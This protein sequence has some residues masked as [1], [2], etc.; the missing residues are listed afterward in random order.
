MTLIL[1]ICRLG[2]PCLLGKT[3]HYAIINAFRLD[4]NSGKAVIHYVDSDAHFLVILLVSHVSGIH[5]Y[6]NSKKRPTCPVAVVLIIRVQM[7]I[8]QP[9]LLPL[10][11]K[12]SI[13]L[14]SVKELRGFGG[15]TLN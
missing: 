3:K 12:V 9:A 15:A 1:Y 10:C 6:K 11:I 4:E 7:C 13:L 2:L 5:V 14:F 8:P